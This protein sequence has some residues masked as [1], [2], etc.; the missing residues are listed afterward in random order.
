L[1]AE[2]SA[3]F[4]AEF[5]LSRLQDQIVATNCADQRPTD[6][7]Q[8]SVP[9]TTNTGKAFDN[10]STENLEGL[11]R[12]GQQEQWLIDREELELTPHQILGRGAFG[13]VIAGSYHGVPVAVKM[14]QVAEG[15]NRRSSLL[16][17]CNEARILRK[18]RHPNIVFFCGMCFRSDHCQVTLVL[19]LIQG[20]VL[21]NYIR[22]E[23]MVP[24]EQR[25][26]LIQDISSALR[27]L[28]SRKPKIIH[29]DL[30]NTNIFTVKVGMQLCAKL[31]EQMT[32][33]A[34]RLGGTLNWMAPEI[35]S[36]RI[37][38]PDVS[39]DVFS[40]GRV[41]FFVLTGLQPSVAV[42]RS[43]TIRI[44]K[45]GRLAKVHSPPER[46]DTKHYEPLVLAC[47]C[48]KPSL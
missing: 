9:E 47:T 32:Q 1:V 30:K 26:K 21:K 23:E 4:T 7:M 36:D 2:K 41:E 43:K 20:T 18:L 28:H 6:E 12:I 22:P 33:H 16:S 27:Y 42:S 29:G 46:F 8:S 39:S 37:L 5:Q 13:V 24:V 17:L 3:R 38:R 25:L 45:S 15:S 48:S 40:F 31:L 35:V 14:V 44:L 11:V 34:K 10:A 19:E